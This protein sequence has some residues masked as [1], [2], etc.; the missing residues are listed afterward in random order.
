[1]NKV[2][3]YSTTASVAALA[4][5]L[6]FAPDTEGTT[7]EWA[8]AAGSVDWSAAAS[9][10]NASTSETGTL[11]GD[12]DDV[13][14][15]FV[16][17]AKLEFSITVPSGFAGTISSRKYSS[18]EK[19]IRCRLEVSPSAEAGDYKLTGAG[20]YVA[21]AS[22][23]AHLATDFSGAIDIPAGVTFTAS[24]DVPT[25]V[26]F[27]GPGTLV[28][29]SAARFEHIGGFTGTVDARGIGSLASTDLTTLAGHNVLL[30]AT[31]TI[32]GTKMMMLGSQLDDW[33]TVGAWAF[34]GVSRTASVAS[35]YVANDT[36]P[37]VQADGSLLMTDDFAQRQ[38]ATLMNRTFTKDDIWQVKFT[39]TPSHDS[40][41]HPLNDAASPNWG[42]GQ[43]GNVC[44]AGIVSTD[45]LADGALPVATG[46]DACP[47]GMSGWRSFGYTGSSQQNLGLIGNGVGMDT[48]NSAC[49][50][51]EAA[52]GINLRKSIDITMT[53]VKAHMFITFRQGTI[54]R[55]IDND[56]SSFI[57][58]TFKFGFFANSINNLWQWNRFSGFS[59]W[60][61]Q[62]NDDDWVAN[63][64]YTGSFSDW[65][66]QIRKFEPDDSTTKVTLSGAA[67]C[68]DAGGRLPLCGAQ[69]NFAGH[70]SGSSPV[71]ITKRNK[72]TVHL[73]WVTSLAS[74]GWYGEGIR[75]MFR[76]SNSNT[77]TDGVNTWYING[78]YPAWIY[79]YYGKYSGFTTQ[80][81]GS[82]SDL[83]TGNVGNL[84]ASDNSSID[85]EFVVWGGDTMSVKSVRNDGTVKEGSATFPSPISEF[86]SGNTELYP[87]LLG[88]SA[89]GSYQET[90]ASNFL[91]YVWKPTNR[92]R[93]FSNWTL[94]DGGTLTVDDSVVVES[95]ATAG[96][97]TLAAGA[98]SSLSCSEFRLGG[99]TGAGA[100]VSL[101][102]DVRLGDSLR[103]EVP[104]A[105]VNARTTVRLIDTA[106][107]TAQIPSTLSI[108]YDDG[109][110]VPADCVRVAN[111]KVMLNF[112]RGLVI[113]FH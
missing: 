106:G 86:Y 18:A 29:D 82:A 63:P 10:K 92:I 85:L 11:P 6:A 97:V 80:K 83:L 17:P 1:M 109:S 91:A 19:A 65:N 48:G 28:V 8:G 68:L 108:V 40:S 9:W 88:A 50:M 39:W 104:K 58:E 111:G 89:S 96:A 22:L 38:T 94:P 102:G 93:T 81:G 75:F 90:W 59:G 25:D 77:W 56:L 23:A 98:D 71:D 113:T 107:S 87:A 54:S 31:T 110:A 33:N 70:G 53:F 57:P 20:V 103:V 72:F 24:S 32:D 12:T 26:E 60:C 79:Y 112:A 42:K 46:N 55:T 64:D 105:W 16:A 21:N 100:A 62:K 74:S 27:F 44:G 5:A 69:K 66:L 101:S 73:D 95:I 37:A 4:A 78:T 7:Y 76:G 34:S 49:A 43:W 47:A 41:A 35:G 13:V 30:P 99:S 84:W 61:Y 2:R 67:N 3:N 36:I 45:R 52:C 15:P 14:F 51:R